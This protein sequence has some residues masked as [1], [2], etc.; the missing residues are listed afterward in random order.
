MY[1]SP[2]LFIQALIPYYFFKKLNRF[3]AVHLGNSELQALRLG[4][5]GSKLHFY[6]AVKLHHKQHEPLM[7]FW[8]AAI[9]I[10][11]RFSCHFVVP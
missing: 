8:Q 7:L 1:S 2:T 6:K 11:L 9:Q 10:F 4:F 3:Q 5:F